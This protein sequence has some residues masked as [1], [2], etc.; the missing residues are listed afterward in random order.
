MTDRGPDERIVLA[1]HGGAGVI[2]RETLP[3][4]VEAAVRRDLADAL[5]AGGQALLRPG[6]TSLD[7]VEQAV[8][9]L[10]DSPVF[11]AGR[12]SVFTR[13]RTIE[14][15]AAIMC[16]QTLRAGALAGVTSLKNPIS[17]AR[18]VMERCEHVLMIGAAAD[19]WCAEHGAEV[20][21]PEYFHTPN[22]LL[23]LEEKLLAAAKTGSEIEPRTSSIAALT[24]D[25]RFGTVGA[26]ALDRA[27]N[28][29]AGTSTGGRSMKRSGRVGDSPLIGAGTYADNAS[30][31]ISA[32][33]DGEFFIRVCCARTIAALV[34]Y[35]GLSLQRAGEEV[36]FRKIQPL[37]GAGGVIILNRRGEAAFPFSTLGMYRGFLTADGRI[38]V[39]IYREDSVP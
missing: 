8:R 32:T 28:L 18:T 30:C 31:A 15:D 35:Q 11:N 25:H 16:G 34:E 38:D 5:T 9:V 7:G 12:G 29:A 37:G 6:G 26:V 27:G 14:L 24:Q 17:A 33:G 1:I 19:R 10:E 21:P 2:A 39:Q 3:A 13:E 23:E 4:D 20:V 22:R 36:L